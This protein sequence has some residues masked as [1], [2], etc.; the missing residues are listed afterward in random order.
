MDLGVIEWCFNCDE[1][2]KR[3]N[4]LFDKVMDRGW[5]LEH[6]IPPFDSD[7]A[8]EEVVKQLSDLGEPCVLTITRVTKP[9][10]SWDLFQANLMKGSEK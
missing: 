7:A 8:W 3:A 4:E 5:L 6:G 10:P 9:S 1:A 2:S